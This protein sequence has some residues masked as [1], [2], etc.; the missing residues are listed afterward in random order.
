M[1][2]EV[3]VTGESPL[4]LLADASVKGESHVVAQMPKR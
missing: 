2:G 1:G 4:H 3:G